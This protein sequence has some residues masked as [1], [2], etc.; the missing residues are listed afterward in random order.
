MCLV[1]SVENFSSVE[2]RVSSVALQGLDLFFTLKTV[3]TLPL[4]PFLRS[5]LSPFPSY[6]QALL[7]MDKLEAIIRQALAAD[8]SGVTEE[9]MKCKGFR[10]ITPK[11]YMEA[12]KINKTT[13]SK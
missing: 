9:D 1:S 3:L 6:Q 12:I 13:P 7:D 2:C 11:E 10:L 8:A 5:Q 4:N